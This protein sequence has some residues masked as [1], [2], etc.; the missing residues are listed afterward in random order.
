MTSKWLVGWSFAALMAGCTSPGD[1]YVDDPG[2]DVWLEGAGKADGSSGVNVASTHLDVDLA[3][4]TAT[5]TIELETYGSVALEAGG[6]T[7]TR[8]SDDRGH[9]HYRVVNG[10]SK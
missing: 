5:A 1:D 7:I 6:L 9:R 4:H 2:D 10:G 8:V 3:A